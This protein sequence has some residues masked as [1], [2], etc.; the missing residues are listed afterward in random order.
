MSTISTPTI[1]RILRVTEYDLLHI[2]VSMGNMYM[3][4]DTMKL[5]FDQGNASTDRVMYNY[6][7]IRTVNDLQNNVSPVWNYTYYCWED[8]SLW[9]WNNKWISLYTDTSYPSAYVYDDNRNITDVYNGDQ[10][11]TVLDNNGLLYFWG[12][13]KSA[14]VE[15][16]TGKG[17]ST[18]DY[19][20]TEKNKLTSLNNNYYGTST[21]QAA[22]QNK[23]VVVS[24]DQNFELKVGCVVAVKFDASNTY[25]ATTDAPVTMNVNNTGAKQIYYADTPTPTGS[26][27]VVFG[28][29]NYV[30]RYMYDGTYWVWVGFSAENNTTYSAISVNELTTGTATNLRTVRADY[31]KTAIN[32][33]IN[34]KLQGISINNDG[35]LII[36]I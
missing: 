24:A 17:L 12:K 35:D 15:K 10:P 8:N 28:H 21:G 18:N 5:Y 6:I 19:T 33:L 9:L 4:Q 20:T 11:Y 14:F 23:A 16:E 1:K 34:T 13:I 26:N 30:M 31:L 32:N 22:L 7:S 3:C 25:N 29:K 2:K 36:T 27:T